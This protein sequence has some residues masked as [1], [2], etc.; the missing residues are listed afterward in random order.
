ML[1]NVQPKDIVSVGEK[2]LLEKDGSSR[3]QFLFVSTVV[4]TGWTLNETMALALRSALKPV[5]TSIMRVTDPLL[6]K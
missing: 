4:I 3:S 1:S 2:F 5:T 6:E